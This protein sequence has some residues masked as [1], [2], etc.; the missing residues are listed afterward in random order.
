MRLINADALWVEFESV[1][2]YDNADRDDVAEELLLKA[3]TIDPVVPG[4]WTGFIVTKNDGSGQARYLHRECEIKPSEIYNS[5]HH[6]CPNCGCKM[7]GQK[8]K[9]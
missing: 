6:Y 8:E 7:D 2:W 9:G 3:P 1:G 5:P 4:R